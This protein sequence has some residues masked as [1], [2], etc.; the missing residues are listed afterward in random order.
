MAE[1]TELS[2]ERLKLIRRF[3]GE[4]EGDGDDSLCV[5]DETSASPNGSSSAETREAERSRM[6]AVRPRLSH[7]DGLPHVD[8]LDSLRVDTAA[9]VG[10]ARTLRNRFELGWPLAAVV[11]GLLVGLLI[12]RTL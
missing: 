5:T 12:A 3:M 4:P 6:P 11:L 7:L 2:A 10:F 8:G 9:L 1:R